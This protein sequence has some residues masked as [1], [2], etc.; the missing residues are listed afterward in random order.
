MPASDELR[1]TDAIVRL[2]KGKL[3][4]VEVRTITETELRAIAQSANRTE[5]AKVSFYKGTLKKAVFQGV[6]FTESNFARVE[7]EGVSF[8]RCKFRRVDFTRANFKECTFSDC[9]FIDCDPYYASFDKTEID[10][11]AFKR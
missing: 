7:F 9:S 10:S 5:I 8:S 3:A 11:S 1:T 6:N 4:G 2:P